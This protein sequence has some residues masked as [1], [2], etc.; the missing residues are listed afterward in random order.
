MTTVPVYNI[1]RSQL[2]RLRHNENLQVNMINML[3]NILHCQ[4]EDIMEHIDDDNMF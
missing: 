2:N 3:Y 4:I 1:N